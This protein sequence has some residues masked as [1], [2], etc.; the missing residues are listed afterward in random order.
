[1]T[2]RPLHVD[3]TRFETNRY[4][5]PTFMT[6]RQA[7]SPFAPDLENIAELGNEGCVENVVDSSRFETN[8]PLHDDSRR[9]VTNRLLPV[10]SQ[11]APDL[12]NIAE[13]GNA[14]C[15]ENVVHS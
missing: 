11:F 14:R 8:R 7:E 9:I 2:N 5:S 15:V 10:G 1:M 13:L 12:Q 4:E 3:S 6:I